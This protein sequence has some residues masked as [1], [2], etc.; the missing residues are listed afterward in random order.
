MSVIYCD[1]CSPSKWKAHL[2][3]FL[4]IPNRPIQRLLLLKT[5]LFL[6]ITC[7]TKSRNLKSD[8]RMMTGSWSRD[9]QNV[10]LNPFIF[11]RPSRSVLGPIW[12]LVNCVGWAIFSEVRKTG[13]EANYSK[14]SNFEF[15][16]VWS[17]LRP[18]EA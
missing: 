14:L 17:Y 11:Y 6:I 10:D 1:D 3:I 2:C 5:K 12:F 8:I 7:T 18:R 13:R 15:K 16:N 9:L 4:N